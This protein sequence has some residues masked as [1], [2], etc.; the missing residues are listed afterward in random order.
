MS[1]LTSPETERARV[2]EFSQL[3][4][5][6]SMVLRNAPAYFELTGAAVIGLSI[7]SL[8]ASAIG[9]RAFV[10]AIQSWTFQP[11]TALVTAIGLVWAGRELRHRRRTSAYGAVL[12]AGTIVVEQLMRASPSFMAIAFAVAGLVILGAIWD[13]LE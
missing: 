9:S 8:I 2:T 4:R 7:T 3:V 13:E 12:A 11:V 10:L 5:E 1:K 6:P